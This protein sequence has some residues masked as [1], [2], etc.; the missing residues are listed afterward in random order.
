MKEPKE[1][2]SSFDFFVSILHATVLRWLTGRARSGT[3]IGRLITRQYL[4]VDTCID[5]VKKG[6]GKGRFP[7]RWLSGAQ[8]KDLRSVFF[9]P[10]G[11]SLNRRSDC[12]EKFGACSTI[13]II[14]PSSCICRPAATGFHDF[15]K[16]ILS[17]DWEIHDV[18]QCAYKMFHLHFTTFSG[19]F[20][21][22]PNPDQGRPMPLDPMASQA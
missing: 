10:C 21:S 20:C 6:L 14:S 22:P 1:L 7:A 17:Q 8:M 3:Q 4:S 16:P 19:S 13:S 5:R 15:G 9:S 18:S 11:S 2:P 12:S